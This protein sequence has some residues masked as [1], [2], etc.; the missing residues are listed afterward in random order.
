MFDI[1]FNIYSFPFKLLTIS[2][3]L[4]FLDKYK[5]TKY[6]TTNVNTAAKIYVP[7]LICTEKSKLSSKHFLNN[8]S[9][10]KYPLGKPI[11]IDKIVI[12]VFCSIKILLV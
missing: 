10:K 6:E 2:I 4:T 12:Q 11:I 8:Q 3:D 1:I 5:D 9:T 7:I